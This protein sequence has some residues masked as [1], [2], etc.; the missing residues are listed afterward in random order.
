MQQN[1]QSN[2]KVQAKLHSIQA[3]IARSQAS[4]KKKFL[5]KIPEKYSK[6]YVKT[7]QIVNKDNPRSSAVATW[8]EQIVA[9]LLARQHIRYEK[10]H[11]ILGKFY[12]FYCAELNLIIEV[13]GIFWHQREEQTD[14]KYK[15]FQ[16]KVR[17]ND[18]Y[19]RAICKA[20]K[21]HMIV[22]YEDRINETNV[23]N[24]LDKVREYDG[25]EPLYIEV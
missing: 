11:E 7:L 19:K 5:L 15:L 17:V 25:D 16:L 20:K 23:F 22:I 14:P 8:P 10:E 12:D 9:T 1:N 21:H 18:M 2:K 4:N 24:A 13:H 6:N 3:K